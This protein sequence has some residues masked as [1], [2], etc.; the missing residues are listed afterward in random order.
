MAST[1]PSSTIQVFWFLFLA[2]LLMHSS[3]QCHNTLL[4]QLVAAA[5]SPAVNNIQHVPAEAVSSTANQRE[6]P[7]CATGLQRCRLSSHQWRCP[8]GQTSGVL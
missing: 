8:C 6:L 4:M 1:G 7:T 3:T 2:A 5:S